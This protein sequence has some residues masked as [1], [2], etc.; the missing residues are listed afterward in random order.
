MS[1][2]SILLN[3]SDGEL[4]KQIKL[5]ERTLKHQTRRKY[6]LGEDNANPEAALEWLDL[7][8]AERARR[9]HPTRWNLSHPWS[10]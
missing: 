7:Y 6:A 8:R 4:S 2:D 5:W 1:L 10:R 3:M 9:R